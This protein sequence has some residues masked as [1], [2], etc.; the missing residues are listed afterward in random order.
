MVIVYL[1]RIVLKGMAIIKQRG[2][3]A[4][5]PIIVA[6][7]LLPNLTP[8]SPSK[9][10]FNRNNSLRLEETDLNGRKRHVPAVMGG[11]RRRL[12]REAVRE[13]RIN[14]YIP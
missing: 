14:K 7:V 3:V 10:H 2:R 6:V 8:I 11:H 4:H 9:R 5:L 13:P 1:S 12:L